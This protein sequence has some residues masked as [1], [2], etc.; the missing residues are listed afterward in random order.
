VTLRLIREPSHNGATLG[1]LYVDGVWQCWVL[2]D[3]MRAEKIKGETAIPAGTYQV[4]LTHSPR[5]NRQLPE[6]LNVPTFVGVRIHGG[7]RK[8]DT[9]GCILVGEQRGDAWIGQ[10]QVALGKLMAKLVDATSIELLIEPP[11]SYAP[12]SA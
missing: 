9:E 11:P 6:L 2:E 8:E 12:V 3:V 10:S 5:F 1:S 7:N 4:K